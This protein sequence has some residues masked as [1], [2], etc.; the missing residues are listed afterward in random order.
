MSRFKSWRPSQYSPL[1]CYR[2]HAWLKTRK[3]RFNSGGRHQYSQ[4]LK[5]E[6]AESLS[7]Q[8]REQAADAAHKGILF[9]IEEYMPSGHEIVTGNVRGHGVPRSTRAWH[10]RGAGAGPVVSTRAHR[11]TGVRQIR[12]LEVRVRFPVGPPTFGSVAQLGRA[13]DLHSGGCRFDPGRIHHFLPAL[14]R[15]GTT[16]STGCKPAAFGLAGSNPAAG[17]TGA[18]A[19]SRP[20]G[21]EPRRAGANPA[22]PANIRDRGREARRHFARVDDADANSA[23]RSMRL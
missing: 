4:L 20:R 23:G 21:L 3:S 7:D 19:N 11:I 1:R 10:A 9:L 2:L 13:P 16:S 17:T 22:A 12:N 15:S 6:P 14:S 8:R 18:S 5:A